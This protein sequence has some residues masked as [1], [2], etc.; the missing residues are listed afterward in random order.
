MTRFNSV[1]FRLCHIR[2]LPFVNWHRSRQSR[3]I[4][5][6]VR[7][8]G[9]PG[10]ERTDPVRAQPD[11]CKPKAPDGWPT[12]HSVMAASRR[13]TEAPPQRLRR[14]R[15]SRA[16]P[17][18]GIDANYR[19]NRLRL[20]VLSRTGRKSIE[21]QSIAAASV[22]DSFDTTACLV[23]GSSPPSPTTHSRANGDFL[24]RPL[25]LPNE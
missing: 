19:Y 1:C 18:F 23:P 2:P 22:G 3:G 11:L 14:G 16:P 10:E 6:G 13:T 20:P 7:D 4:P 9:L 21:R 5:N 24:N 12:L 15:I 25:L 8:S 17:P